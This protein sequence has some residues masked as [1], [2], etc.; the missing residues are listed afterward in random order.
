[1]SRPLPTSRRHLGAVIALSVLGLVLAAPTGAQATAACSPAPVSTELDA[2]GWDF[3]ESRTGGHHEYVPGGLRVWTD[4]AD[5]SKAKSAGY[6]ATDFA[7][8]D[9]GSVDLDVTQSSGAAPGINL[10]IYVDGVWK[11]NLVHE[12]LF[13][14]WW[15]NKPIA[16][17][18]AGP[19]PSYQ[20]AYGTLDEVV[21][22]YAANN[23]TDVR[24][25]A[26]G[27]SLGSGA[28]GDAVIHSA[29][30][31]CVTHSFGLAPPP[32]P[33]PSP[34]GPPTP[35]ALQTSTTT[36]PKSSADLVPEAQ[37]KATITGDLR[38]GG[39]ILVTVPGHAGEQVEIV[40]FSTPRSL[41]V[42]TLSAQATA[43]TTLP[44]DLTAGGHSVA[45]YSVTGALIAWAPIAVSADE[46][47]ATG[48]DQGALRL[49]ILVTL[50]AGTAFV[51][52]SRP[53]RPSVARHRR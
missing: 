48:T 26:I 16:G 33:S 13:A 44:T 18:P 29:T 2:A 52:V 17:L 41:G 4:G 10:T 15:I 11:G 45:A 27:F 36:P 14:D 12:P 24:V 19:N 47:A 20:L 37:G 39:E 35:V 32:S 34:T 6:V 42:H 40:V 1:M 23:V 46:L 50:L 21:A 53:T 51:L 8:A 43:S 49:T 28:I 9:A 30:A 7:L 3:S 38:P 22:A 31:G 25:R 5:L